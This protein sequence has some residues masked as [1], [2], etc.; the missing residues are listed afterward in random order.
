VT[1]PAKPPT[2]QN[3]DSSWRSPL[4]APTPFWQRVPKFFLLPLQQPAA[5][6]IISLAAATML[7]PLALH[8]GFFG[9]LLLAFMAVAILVL[10]TQFGFTIIERSSQGF[11]Q[12][13]DYPPRVEGSSLAR[14]F[15]YFAVNVIFLGLVIA[16]MIVTRGSELVA[17]L[18]WTLLFAVAMPAAVMRLVMTGSLG[19]ALNPLAIAAVITYWVAARSRS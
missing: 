7:V 19:A 10:G 11:L 9:L 14:P 17:W 5:V 4:E 16:A 8:L 3:G 12:T 18:A 15:K 6:R 2:T 1:A 13:S